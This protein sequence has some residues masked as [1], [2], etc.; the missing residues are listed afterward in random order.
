MPSLVHLFTSS[1]ADRHRP[2]SSLAGGRFFTLLAIQLIAVGLAL[3]ISRDLYGTY[4]EVIGQHDRLAFKVQ[5]I[6][7]LSKH[8]DRLYKSVEALP[9]DHAQE[10]RDSAD[11][12]LVVASTELLLN[13][14]VELPNEKAIVQQRVA[15]LNEMRLTWP[16]N[17]QNRGEAEQ[18][19]V[20]LEWALGSLRSGL[21]RVDRENF[22]RL[23]DVRRI[24]LWNTT[25]EVLACLL[26]F[27][28]FGW[29][30]Q[31]YQRLR[32]EELNRFRM[33]SELAA[34]RRALEKRVKSRT[35]ALEAE[36]TKRK[37]T[38][39]LNRGRSRMLEMGAR[40]EPI[41]KILQVLADTLAE[42]RSNWGCAVHTVDSGLLNLT[43][44]SGLSEQV[45]EQLRSIS[46]EYSGAPESMALTLG[47]PYLIED[48]GEEHRTWSELL[49]AN[50]LLSVW[51][52]P[53]FAPDSCV[54]GTIT[55]YTRLR[56]NPSS[57]DIEMLEAAIN[58]AVLVLERRRMQAQLMDHAY[59][60]SLTGLPNR[61]LGLDRL[62][63]AASRAER[64][65]SSM[66]VLWIDL[67]R[68]K[69]INDRH[70][71]PVGDAV[72]QEAAKR[73]TGR[74]RLSDTLARMGGDEFMAVLEGI[75]G[76][77]EAEALASDLLAILAPPMQ[78]DEVELRLTASIGVS[79]YPDD[80]KTVESLAQHADQAMY[81]AKFGRCGVRSFSQEMDRE[82]AERRELE[83]EM[84][85]ALATG[86][87]SL[88]YQPLC[89]PDGTLSGFEALL[90]FNSPSLGHLLPSHFI[91]IAEESRLIVPIGEWV[92]RQVCR[93]IREWQDA[94]L[95][96]ASIAV[97]IS[98]LQFAR[99]DFADTV[100]KIIAETGISG[101]NLVLELTES[102]VM[103]DFSESAQQ[104]KRLKKLGV[105]IAIDD[106]GTGYSSLSCLHRLPIDVLKID[107]S[108][109][110]NLNEK[111]DTR[112]I[113]EAVLSMAS[114]LGLQVVAEGV[115]TAAQLSTLQKCG[116]A[117]IQ[118][119]FFSR[120]VGCDSAAAFL[121][122]GNLE[123]SEEAV[124]LALP[125][126]PCEEP[127]AEMAG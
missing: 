124:P 32:R 22:A 70:G 78:I 74:L 30:A 116:C 107:R 49:R 68:F 97:N 3:A 62:T 75:G 12:N 85:L 61:R 33:E 18:A 83:E 126:E 46:T 23:Y 29:T 77:E 117:L 35:A 56:W 114:T 80:G 87:F 27:V 122:R 42:Y 84:A 72:L 127:L 4:R 11:L 100:A 8:L 52:A 6:D 82:P 63:S 89:L 38:S 28:A 43:A 112:P 67:N 118:G 10:L 54:L 24:S 58:M 13:T 2:P 69:Q 9:A 88:A 121:L 66:A 76:R 60:D 79:L 101:G 16:P 44:S 86:G 92:L 40:N 110:E 15:A 73:L 25:C 26:M 111:D 119:Y 91:P 96:K 115:E 95:P 113:V 5:R 57:E 7:H 45:K 53:F 123:G 108:F 109:M 65:G 50:R 36:V 120:P 59:H 47:K 104:M 21:D 14:M 1:N 106:F 37:R 90:R 93:Q 81:A 99:D 102:I 17:A 98:S 20:R 94:G 64:S 39:R 19:I 125:E 55:I 51:S 48:L 71:H 34:E 31:L 41:A 105:R 103:N